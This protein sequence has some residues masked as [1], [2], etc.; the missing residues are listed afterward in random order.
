MVPCDKTFGQIYAMCGKV[1]RVCW[2]CW[3]ARWTGLE[4]HLDPAHHCRRLALGI[5]SQRRCLWRVLHSHT[6]VR[7]WVSYF[8]RRRRGIR[9]LGRHRS[10]WARG[11]VEAGRLQSL[12]P[13]HDC[14]RPRFLPVRILVDVW[15][16]GDW[17]DLGAS[18]RGEGLQ[19]REQVLDGWR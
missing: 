3:V 16:V 13:G 12:H 7:P 19:R 1:C 9:E 14:G 6:G 10:G 5:R 18:S 4:P 15:A 17:A 11:P 8:Q 2:V